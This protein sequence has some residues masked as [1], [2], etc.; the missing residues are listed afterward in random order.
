MEFS[1]I[2]RRLVPASPEL[3]AGLH[4]VLRRIYAARGVIDD[5]G[6]DLSLER[7]LPIGSLPG[8]AAAAETLLEHRSGRVLVV[9]DFDA[10]GATSSALVM[11]G[12]RRL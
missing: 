9:G 7:L 8:V 2:R 12:L 4:P 3:G 6:L 11:R 10:D 1:E 5:E